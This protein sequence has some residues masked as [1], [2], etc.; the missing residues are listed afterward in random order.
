MGVRIN[1]NVQLAAL[2][3]SVILAQSAM[4]FTIVKYCGVAYL[5]YMGIKAITD[6]SSLFANQNQSVEHLDL[7][8]IYRQ[9]FFTNALNPKV[10]LFFLAFMPQFINTKQAQGSMPFVILGLTFMITGTLWCLFLAYG[11]S[12][13]TQTLRNNDHIGRWM[14]KISGAIFIGLGMKL[15]MSKQ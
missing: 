15:L 12:L 14:Q 13:V 11:A 8:K 2:G 6:K 7:W 9:G 10:A 4:A 3:L 1:R 5:V